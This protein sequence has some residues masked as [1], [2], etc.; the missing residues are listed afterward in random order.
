MV[1]NELFLWFVFVAP[2]LWRKKNV[3]F[4]F[5]LVA[6]NLIWIIL[7]VRNNDILVFLES[8]FI[9]LFVKIW[10]FHYFELFFLP[11]LYYLSRLWLSIFP[12]FFFESLC[13]LGPLSLFLMGII[14]G[15]FALNDRNETVEEMPTKLMLLLNAV[16]KEL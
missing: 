10:Y 1:N 15:L 7:R 16:D 6:F 4:W 12:L 5:I 14:Q 13:K 9:F 11:S 2:C 3:S 8:I